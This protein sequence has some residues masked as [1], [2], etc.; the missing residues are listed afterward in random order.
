ARHHRTAFDTAKNAVETKKKPA[1]VQ[2]TIAGQFVYP[3]V[4]R[5]LSRNL[6][7]C[8]SDSFRAHSESF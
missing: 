1:I 5:S 6:E 2:C 8:D 7:L 3:T 4:N